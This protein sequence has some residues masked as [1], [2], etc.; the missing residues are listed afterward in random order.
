MKNKE[1]ILTKLDAVFGKI[2][3]N[4]I[5]AWKDKLDDTGSVVI[6]EDFNKNIEEEDHKEYNPD[7]DIKY[8]GWLEDLQEIRSL[9]EKL[10]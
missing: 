10:L 4:N 2:A 3:E 9:I 8:N 5:D 6:L 7:L 1:E